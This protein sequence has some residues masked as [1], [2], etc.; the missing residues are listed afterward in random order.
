MAREMNKKID[1]IDKKIVNIMLFDADITNRELA[2]KCDIA[3][4]T[5]NNR[6]K[7]LRKLGVIKNKT[8]IV[9]YEK[10][11]YTIQVLIGIRIRK[12][13][14][15]KIAKKLISH[16][17]VFTVMDMTGV[18]DGEILAR[19]NTTRQL[20]S[21]IKKLQKDE[22]IIYTR[23]KLILNIYRHQEVK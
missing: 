16:P 21:F 15:H 18:Y 14:F 9:D 7:R 23:T 4:G 2:R 12:G 10:L 1:D 8:I 3:L 17:H 11:G 13:G 5:A 19:F 20:D 22:D 6:L